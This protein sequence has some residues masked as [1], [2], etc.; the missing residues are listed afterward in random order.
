MFLVYLLVHVNCVCI[1]DHV[2]LLLTS[3]FERERQL[4]Q[5]EVINDRIQVL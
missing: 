3:N 2:T 1:T 4:D 5:V